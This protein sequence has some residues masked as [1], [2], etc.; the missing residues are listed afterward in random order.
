MMFS[1]R[2]RDRVTLNSSATLAPAKDATAVLAARL[3][4]H[5][6]ERVSFWQRLL[7]HLRS[8]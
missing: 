8:Q 4:D 7:E 5:S 2:L 3:A 6:G 1:I